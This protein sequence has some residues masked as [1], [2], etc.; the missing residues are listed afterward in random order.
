MD[1][2][3]HRPHHPSPLAN[4]G[5]GAPPISESLFPDEPT[6]QIEH[7]DAVNRVVAV[8]CPRDKNLGVGIAYRTQGSEFALEHGRERFFIG[9]T[10]HRGCSVRFTLLSN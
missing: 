8:P 7:P 9:D 1:S 6:G 3:G 2:R 10:S 4:R 5:A